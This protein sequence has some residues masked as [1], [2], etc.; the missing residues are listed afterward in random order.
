MIPQ[1][2]F[3]KSCAAL[4]LALQ[5][6]PE[7]T[8]DLA[9]QHNPWFITESVKMASDAW[10]KLLIPENLERWLEK[11]TYND[12]AWLQKNKDQIPNMLRSYDGYLY[13]GM[14]VNKKFVERLKVNFA[15]VLED[16]PNFFVDRFAGKQFFIDG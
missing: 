14:V 11:S 8:L 12:A 2:S 5:K 1:T 7:P 15:L 3:Q 16:F 6:I 10:I 13:R 9:K 4:S